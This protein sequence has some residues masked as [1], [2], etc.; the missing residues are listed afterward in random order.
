MIVQVRACKWLKEAWLSNRYLSVSK[1]D[2]KLISLQRGKE[3]IVCQ[4][5]NSTAQ[6]AKKINPGNKNKQFIQLKISQLVFRTK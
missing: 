5:V 2:I 6:S 1:T 3:H 4:S